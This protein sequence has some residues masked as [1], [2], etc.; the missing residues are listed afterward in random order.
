MLC[1]VYCD[2]TWV[3]QGE[4]CW[5]LLETSNQRRWRVVSFL[6]LDNE[7]TQIETIITQSVTQTCLVNSQWQTQFKDVVVVVSS[8]KPTLTTTNSI[9][10]VNLTKMSK[11]Q[12]HF[13]YRKSTYSKCSCI[14]DSFTTNFTVFFLQKPNRDPPSLSKSF[15]SF[16]TPTLIDKFVI[17]LSSYRFIINNKFSTPSK[18]TVSFL[19]GGCEFEPHFRPMIKTILRDVLLFLLFGCYYESRKRDLKKTLT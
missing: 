10:G 3:V 17:W 4:D 13:L 7:E 12:N 18:L 2:T 14:N 9:K 19:F 5:G 6:Q 15:Q 8:R 11:S 1:D 16:I